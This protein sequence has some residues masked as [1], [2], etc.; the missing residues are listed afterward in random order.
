MLTCEKCLL[1]P[2]CK[3]NFQELLYLFADS[4]KLTLQY[5]IPGCGHFLDQLRMNM[6]T[7]YTTQDG[8]LIRIYIPLTSKNIIIHRGS[9][10]MIF[11]IN[12]PLPPYENPSTEY[13]MAI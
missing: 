6:R 7:Y 13:P 1:F 2:I 9:F 10:E 11:G 4:Y 5:F 3:S 8:K 12:E